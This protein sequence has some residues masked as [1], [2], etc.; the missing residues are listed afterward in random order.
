[1]IIQ[2]NPIP[3]VFQGI[4]KVSSRDFSIT[5]VHPNGKISLICYP[6]L[7]SYCCDI[8]EKKNISALKR[9]LYV[10]RP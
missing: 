4:E 10:I 2:H 5:C 7:I 9:N 1:M 6:F 8:V 3:H